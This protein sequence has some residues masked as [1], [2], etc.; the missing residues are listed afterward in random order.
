MSRSSRNLFLL[1][2]CVI[3]A[4]AIGA[5]VFRFVTIDLQTARRGVPTV[6]VRITPV[7]VTEFAD[8]IEALG[9]A[10]ANESVTITAQVTDT[11]SAINFRDGEVVEAGTILVELT[12][13]EEGADLEAARASLVEAELQYERA[14]DLVERGTA[15]QARL[16]TALSERNQA[17]ARVRGIEARLADRL[18][19]APFDGILG[20]RS[21]SP[22][23]LLTPGTVITTLDDIDP[24]KLDFSVPETFFSAV[25]AG[26][27]IQAISDAYP[28]E[29]FK[30]LITAVD[31]RIDPET[32]A[33]VA[34]AIIPNSDL[35][36]RPGM[37]M[38]VEIIKNR[39][40][41]M[42]VPETAL[43]PLDTR[44]FVYALGEDSI[45]QRVQII[46][47]ARRPGEVEVLSGLKV[48]QRI[49]TAGTNRI[50]PG[51]RVT[52]QSS[53]A[54]AEDPGEPAG[55]APSMR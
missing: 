46:T 55:A 32:R 1:V 47:G 52:V 26:L 3:I 34:R 54:P 4:A 30:G 48:G 18:V 14:V 22:G 12:D 53:A 31:T 29:A 27:T 40:D 37:L 6:P 38:R 7:I 50:R 45:A 51:Q 15:T 20:L 9:T 35:R 21:V 28:G 23:T 42:T 43:V 17:R 16:D 10:V 36:L 25:R 13:T 8:R 2:V 33:V 49:I 39:R 24:V 44:V 19:R 41:S 5:G 11:V